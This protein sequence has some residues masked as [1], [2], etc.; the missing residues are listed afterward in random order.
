[1]SLIPL[2]LTVVL[3]TPAE[4]AMRTAAEHVAAEN[5][6]RARRVLSDAYAADPRPELLYSLAQVERIAGDCDE[7]RRLFEQF[8]QAASEEDAADARRLSTQCAPAEPGAVVAPAEEPEP[9]P[10]RVA[11]VPNTTT[12]PPGTPEPQSINTTKPWSRRPL[13]AAMMGI[14]LGALGAGVGV[15]AYAALNRPTPDD[16]P[17]EGDYGDL[18]S[19]N[20]RLNI[21]GASVTAVGASLAIGAG[22]IWTVLARRQRA[23]H[24]DVDVDSLSIRF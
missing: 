17:N 12:P 16:A 23:Q 7:A 6:G 24:L 3:A 19:R 20:R 18:T 5:F 4:D 10:A 15:L 22:I 1:M 9:P 13:P 2:I 11:L 14:G 21:A 8:A